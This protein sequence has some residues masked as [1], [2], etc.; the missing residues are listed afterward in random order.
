MKS[1][2]IK[3]LYNIGHN[4]KSMLFMLLVFAF[5][6]IPYSGPEAYIIT[7]GVLCSMMVITTFSFDDHSKWMK[8]AMVTPISKKDL[9]ASKFIVLLI[10]SA[11]GVVFGL[12]IGCIGG[13]LVHK[14][15]YSNVSSLLT[16]PFV[17]LVGLV[18]AE[19]F[20]SVSIPLLFKFGAEKARILSLISFIVPAVVCF[21][22]Y[23]LLRFFG[24]AFTDLLIF[25]LLCSSPVI[26]LVWNLLMYKIS[27]VIFSKRE[28]LF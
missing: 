26:A 2:I 19:I 14:I 18:V 4:A 25:I 17:T 10:F 16:L 22:A 8:Y 20:G 23:E 3:D 7:S 28:L 6:F 5:V 13:I 15:D 21:G 12:V 27:Y 24:I 11:V 9:V 1:L